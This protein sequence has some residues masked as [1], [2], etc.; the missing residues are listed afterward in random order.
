MMCDYLR[1]RQKIFNQQDQALASDL[2][3]PYILYTIY[4]WLFKHLID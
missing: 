1:I 2:Y 4:L 3:K